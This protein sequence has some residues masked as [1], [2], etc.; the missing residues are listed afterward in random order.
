MLDF[1]W[2]LQAYLAPK[3]M[4]DLL[5]WFGEKNRTWVELSVGEW[6]TMHFKVQVS[7]DPRKLYENSQDWEVLQ[8][9]L[10]RQEPDVGA[11]AEGEK[12]IWCEQCGAQV[13]P[14]QKFCFVCDNEL[15][16]EPKTIGIAEELVANLRIYSGTSSWPANFRIQRAQDGI[17]GGLMYHGEVDGHPYQP[18]QAEIDLTS[19]QVRNPRPG[20]LTS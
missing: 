13:Q 6:R 10:G 7:I 12:R 20:T 4:A 18:Y 8:A 9:L 15:L 16:Q 19:M 2:S 5:N 3:A 14:D 1:V 11:G 17:I